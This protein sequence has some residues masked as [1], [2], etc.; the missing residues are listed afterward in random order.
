MPLENQSREKLDNLVSIGQLH[1]EPFDKREFDGLVR[2]ARDRLNDVS[3]G[4]LSFSS[5]FDL[6]YNAGHALGLAALRY[7]D[8]RSDNR[9][10]VFQCLV[11]TLGFSAAEMRVFM[12]CHERRNLAE[13]EGHL[14]IDESL[15]EELIRLTAELLMRVERRCS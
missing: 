11:H 15:L 1:R 8:Y 10:Q 6:T 14:E 13:Y 5:R 4:Q 12:L 3:N 9:F 2:S 7:N